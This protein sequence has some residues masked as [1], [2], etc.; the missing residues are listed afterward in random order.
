MSTNLFQWNHNSFWLETT[1]L[2]SAY[3]REALFV[4]QE[5]SVQLL[6]LAVLIINFPVSRLYASIKK[7]A[8]TEAYEY[9][10]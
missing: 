1:T 8:S 10:S 2:S 7:T 6:L 5:F 4:S 9:F 3:L